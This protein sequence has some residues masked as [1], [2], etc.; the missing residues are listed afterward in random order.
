M[1]A[2]ISNLHVA[3]WLGAL[4]VSLPA[5]C[6]VAGEPIILGTRRAPLEPAARP[7][8]DEKFEQ[9]LNARRVAN[10]MNEGAAALSGILPAPPVVPSRQNRNSRDEKANWMM[11]DRGELSERE[12][13]S[14]LG[15]DA[16]SLEKGSGRRDYF[17]ER[18]DDRESGARI[19]QP[20]RALTLDLNGK[21]GAASRDLSIA[22]FRQDGDGARRTDDK[23]READ[24]TGAG[25]NQERN[26]SNEPGLGPLMNPSRISGGQDIERWSA[27][28]SK[29]MERRKTES[30]EESKE[31]REQYL[32]YLNSARYSGPSYPANSEWGKY[33]REWAGSAAE[34]A[35]EGPGSPGQASLLGSAGRDKSAPIA[36]PAALEKRT[37][38]AA[39]GNLSGVGTLP[40]YLQQRS[41]PSSG[42][43]PKVDYSVPK[44]PGNNFGFR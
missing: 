25:K 19:R 26:A 8:L 6:G 30:V 32:D 31:R 36:S 22:L 12:D 39:S 11:L 37:L 27:S 38:P 16:L 15:L 14:T 9:G 40:S 29:A 24:N 1:K 43:A 3:A 18:R 44:A 2:S 5:P 10:P 35:A 7:R 20:G 23:S 4:V 34:R 17:F 28:I 33:Q 21:P 13:D 41:A 42:R